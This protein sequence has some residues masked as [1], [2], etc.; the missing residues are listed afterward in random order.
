FR[1]CERSNSVD[2]R[3]S[4][5]ITT[6]LNPYGLRK[7]CQERPQITTHLNPYGPGICKR[8]SP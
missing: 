4:N 1:E 6:H 7:A 2:R 3:R 5:S 8:D